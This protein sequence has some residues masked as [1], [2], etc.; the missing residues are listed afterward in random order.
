MR[1]ALVATIA[2]LILACPAV[3]L[4]IMDTGIDLLKGCQAIVA[5][6]EKRQVDAATAG[7]ALLCSGYLMGM[8]DAEKYLKDAGVNLFCLPNG[9]ISTQQAARIVLKYLNDHPEELHRE[10]R[11][12]VYLSL[13]NAYP[14][15]NN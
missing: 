8:I 2:V 12:L 1:K 4:A 15:T 11:T 13:Y 6:A 5:V 10:P 9:G 14:C 7:N 3:A